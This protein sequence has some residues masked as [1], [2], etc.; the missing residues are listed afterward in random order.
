MHGS[1]LAALVRRDV[2][3]QPDKGKPSERVGRKATGLSPD[4]SGYGGR[5]A[6]RTQSLLWAVASHTAR[7]RL[8]VIS[9]ERLCRYLALSI[10][11]FLTVLSLHAEAT[12]GQ[13]TQSWLDNGGGA[14]GISVERSLGNTG[15]FAEIA[16]TSATATSYTDTLLADG[17]N[18]CYRVRSYNATAYSAYSNTAC[19][20]TAQAITLS[21]APTGTGSGV[22]ISTQAGI[23]CG[24]TCSAT[25][26]S[27]T[28]VTLTATP[29]TGST[30]AGWSGG[31]CT[32]TGTCTV[33]VTAPTTV[34][35]TFTASPVVPTSTPVGLTVTTAGAGSG[36]ITSSPAGITCGTTCS[37]TYSPGTALTLTAAATMGST[38]TGWSGACTG[39]SSCSVTLTS[40]TNV[41]ATFSQQQTQT[42]YQTLMV[43][44]SGKGSVTSSP[45]GIQ[46]G[47]TCSAAYLSSTWVTLTATAGS[48]NFGFIGWSGA[49]SGTG[50]C[51]VSMSTA[52][53]VNATFRN[54]NSKGH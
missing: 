5:V 37:A 53:T 1:H 13:L 50:P 12:A 23:L 6:G 41:T 31:G 18:Y 51:T 3:P 32:G 21:V 44:V 7:R 19:G 46:C 4:L 17:T 30:F 24:T 49:C 38:F 39:T 2:N 14:T 9:L 10:L 52:Q 54:L 42:Q 11:L 8:A 28:G 35:A 43:G 22:V 36:T 48:G 20:T 16:T 34:T 26:G 45:A 25:Y 33:T 29:A 40:E 47:G 15:A 27:G